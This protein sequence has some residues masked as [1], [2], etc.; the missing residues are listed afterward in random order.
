MRTANLSSVVELLDALE[1]TGT[2]AWAWEVATDDVQWSM[3]LGPLYGRKRGYQ[4]ANY[5]QWIDLIEPADRAVAGEA[6][7]RALEDGED[8]EFEIR[9]RWP[10]QSEHWLWARGHVVAD[11]DGRAARI[12]GV[13]TD[14]TRNKR[15]HER[16]R[17]LSEAG[18]ILTS[19]LDVT[20]MLE[21]SGFLLVESVADWCS[22]QL[23]VD[24]ML[25]PAVIAHR[26][27]EMLKLAEKIEREY[28]PDRIPSGLAAE[29]IASGSAILIDEVSEDLLAQSARDEKHLSLLLS[30]GLRSAVLSPIVA[31]DRVVGIVSLVAAE[32][33]DHFDEADVELAMEFGKRAGLA[34]EN[35]N[36]VTQLR[37]LARSLQEALSPPLATNRPGVEAAAWYRPAGIG[38]VGGDWYDVIDTPQGTH[39]YVIGDVVGRGIEAVAAM[40]ELR[41]S[42]RMLLMEGRGLSDSLTSLD[43]LAH[44][45]EAFCSTVLCAEVDPKSRSVRLASAGHLSPLLFDRNQGPNFIDIEVGPPLGMASP[46]PD[47]LVLTVSEDHCL[48]LY[49]D[50]VIERRHRDIDASFRALADTV[51]GQDCDPPEIAAALRTLAS[52]TGSEDDATVVVVR[53]LGA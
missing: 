28:P 12:I 11:D 20:E 48:V 39:V 27:P 2:A 41:F 51:V 3:N 15:Q 45:G 21:R 42:L 50:G 14:V 35:S 34:I 31:R 44:S 43:S 26:D 49:T 36:L 9:V 16:D 25:E 23:L 22:I 33:G 29:V 18:N 47:E 1:G 52:E 19:T 40:A 6:V 5:Q 24:G 10:D 7:R 37:S 4:P 13:V 53:V 30:L 46:R 8:Y 32:S 38:D 17:F